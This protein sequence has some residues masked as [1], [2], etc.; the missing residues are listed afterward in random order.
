MS[1]IAND[2][3]R[4]KPYLLKAVFSSG[5]E[6]LSDLVYEAKTVELNKVNTDSTY[7]QRVKEGF[8]QVMAPGG[9]GYG[10]VDYSYLPAGKTGTAQSF[11][12][13]DGD[14]KIDT[15]TITNTF[16]SYVPYDNP[17]VVFTV[18]SPDVSPEDAD[19]TYRSRINRRISQKVSQK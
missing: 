13:T 14:G 12:D 15:A 18:I 10:Y 9:T 2:G 11:L 4:I 8:R 3:V 17:E 1:T 19:D 7:M 5:G 6:K 16:S